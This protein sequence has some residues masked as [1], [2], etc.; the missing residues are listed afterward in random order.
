MSPTLK[1]A[2][3]YLWRYGTMT[4]TTIDPIDLIRD[5][6]ITLERYEG[7]PIKIVTKKPKARPK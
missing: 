3:R 7:V 1:E 4:D 5:L 6:V 2:R